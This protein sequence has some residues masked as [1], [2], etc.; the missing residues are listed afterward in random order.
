[1]SFSL[2]H[3][4]VGAALA[5]VSHALAFTAMGFYDQPALIERGAGPV[6]SVAGSLSDYAANAEIV[7]QADNAEIMESVETVEAIDSETVDV[8]E[9]LD[10]SEPVETVA[11]EI[12]SAVA[13][14]DLET[15]AIISTAL[16]KD[17]SP[18][19]EVKP[20]KKK[21]AV[22]RLI[23]P[24]VRKRQKNKNDGGEAKKTRKAKRKPKARSRSGN[25]GK[26]KH[27]RK[28]GGGGKRQSTVAGRAA[29]SNFKGRVR[30][31]VAGRARAARGRG[32]VVVRFTVTSSGGV[33]GVRVI[34]GASGALNRAALRAVSGGFPPIPPR[35]PAP[36]NLHRSHRVSVK[37]GPRLGIPYSFPVGPVLI[38]PALSKCN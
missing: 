4:A 11:I 6:V 3:W 8:D 7:P 16:S 19:R 12:Q 36:D 20:V 5:L 24:A 37:I 17:I 26:R 15:Q 28:R 10:T 32:T 2:R 35:P 9:P 18:K 14:A 1:M 13:P 27:S 31:R 29:L 33:S 34:R 23:R 22:M 38:R 30:A 21:T 25:G